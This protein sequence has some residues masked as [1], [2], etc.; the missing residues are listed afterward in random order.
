VCEP[1]STG[2]LIP[3]SNGRGSP[4][5][6]PGEW[7]SH[8]EPAGLRGH[9][10]GVSAVTRHRRGRPVDDSLYEAVRPMLAVT[11]GRL[12]ALSTPWAVAA[13]S[14]RPGRGQRAGTAVGCLP[15][16]YLAFRQPSWTRNAVRC[17]PRVRIRVRVRVR[18]PPCQRLRSTTCALPSTT[19]SCHCSERQREKYIL[20]VDLGQ[21]Q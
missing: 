2:S 8:L 3:G 5:R 11:G 1:C 10:P 14:G 16:K 13:G 12:V 20:A 17:Y 19:T 7:L 4:L 18:R 9:R 15:T 6:P 21:V